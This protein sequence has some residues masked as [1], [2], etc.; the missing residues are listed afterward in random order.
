MGRTGWRRA[1]K[2]VSNFLQKSSTSIVRSRGRGGRLAARELQNSC[3]IFLENVEVDCQE[4]RAR[5]NPNQLPGTDL[6]PGELIN[7]SL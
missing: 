2:L 4:S 5:A 6:P 3:P 7:P 1:T